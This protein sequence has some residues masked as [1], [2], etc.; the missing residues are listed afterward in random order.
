MSFIYTVCA[1][2]IK[3]QLGAELYLYQFRMII[4]ALRGCQYFHSWASPSTVAASWA[5]ESQNQPFNIAFATT[6]VGPK[7]K[8]NTRELMSIARQEFMKTITDDLKNL[9]TKAIPQPPKNRPG[10]CPEYLTWPIVCRQP[11]RYKTL[12]F[13]TNAQDPHVYRCCGHCERTLEHLGANN[14]TIDDLWQT[15]SMSVGDVS[16]SEGGY[17]GKQ[18]KPLNVVLKEYGGLKDL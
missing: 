1:Q 18:L 3:T 12:C 13:T 14:I 5:Q 15:S 16:M 6:C 9:S 8:D 7:K 17:E 10:N 2:N 11:G 4:E